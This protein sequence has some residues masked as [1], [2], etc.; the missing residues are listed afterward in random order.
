MQDERIQKSKED[1][2]NE[3]LTHF[4]TFLH[5][6]VDKMA[7]CDVAVHID[8][9]EREYHPNEQITGKVLVTVQRP[10]QCQKLTITHG[11][12]THGRGNTDSHSVDEQLL[13][14]GHWQ[15]GEY[16]YAF[17]FIIPATGHP[18]SY[19]GR[20]LSLDWCLRA[21]VHIER[22]I[23]P[24]AEQS[25]LLTRHATPHVVIQERQK[26]YNRFPSFYILLAVLAFV[27]YCAVQFAMMGWQSQGIIL[28]ISALGAAGLLL[29]LISKLPK[30]LRLHNLGEVRLNL[31]KYEPTRRQLR[32]TL[33]LQAKGNVSV[34]SIDIH[35][36]RE[37]VAVSGSG[38][39]STTHRHQE[40]MD[41]STPHNNIR[42]FSR[43]KKS[44]DFMLKLPEDAQT[45]IDLS[46]NKLIW[47]VGFDI[48]LKGEK[49]LSCRHPIEVAF[50]D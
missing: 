44:I 22:R 33:V 42:L 17:A 39:S 31:D 35:L 48:E 19:F 3:S 24:T 46:D 6:A 27:A 16:Q 36:L 37:E 5:K 21:Q 14:Q 25:Y 1:A 13:Y 43:Q 9:A 30:A 40:V 41:K 45:T 2:F 15:P 23:N 10:I 49:M 4:S 7:G 18:M 50:T 29:L 12:K 8:E 38:T 32:G 28:L 34:D 11:Y 26:V 47:Y 20:Y